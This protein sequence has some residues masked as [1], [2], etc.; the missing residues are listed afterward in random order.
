MDIVARLIACLLLALC[1]GVA[2]ADGTVAS[3]GT[4]TWF[5]QQG[6]GASGCGGANV[7]NYAWPTQQAAA[8]WDKADAQASNGACTWTLLNQNFSGGGGTY[9][10]RATGCGPTVDYSRSLGLVNVQMACPTNAATSGGVC[11][12][13]GGYVPNSGA[14]ACV[15]A[16]G[17]C[18][19]IVAAMNS[20]GQTV[21]ST[22]APIGSLDRCFGGC[23]VSATFCGSRVSAGVVSSVCFGPFTA[24]SGTCSQEAVPPSAAASAPQRCPTGQCPGTVGGV[25]VCVPCTATASGSSSAA[26]APAGAGS[27]PAGLTPGTTSSKTVCEGAKCTTTTTTK[28]PAGVV[29]GIETE[30][31]P[32]ES[33]CVENPDTTICKSSSFSGTCGAAFACDGDAIQCAIAKEQYTRNCMLYEGTNDAVTAAEQA[34][35]AGRLPSDHP[36]HAGNVTTTDLSGGFTQTELLGSAACPTPPTFMWQGQSF[37]M[38]YD[39][40]CEW[41]PILGQMLVAA[42]AVACAFIAFKRD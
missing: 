27:A 4:A 42:C 20:L 16:S 41:A 38:D 15:V 28:D 30:I 11:V 13:N 29:T 23:V 9:T 14:T 21:E 7:L 31:E 35:D 12:C 36:G 40:L 25:S 6:W 24:G 22:T 10:L 32:K 5:C 26:S 1:A 37:T 34:V 3:G 17:A 33:F 19:T 2:H 8:D 18:S 39:K